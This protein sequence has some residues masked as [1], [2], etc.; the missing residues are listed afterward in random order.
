MWVNSSLLKGHSHEAR[1]AVTYRSAKLETKKHG[2]LVNIYCIFVQT[3]PCECAKRESAI[4][5]DVL[6]ERCGATL[7]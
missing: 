7:K 1:L 5:L 4:Q 3:Y 2:I 6:N